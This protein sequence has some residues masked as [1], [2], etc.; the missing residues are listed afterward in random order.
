[1][2]ENASF[3]KIIP[4]VIRSERHRNKTERR[5]TVLHNVIP[6]SSKKFF[7]GTLNKYLMQK[8]QL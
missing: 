6:N 7:A 8:T 2:F 1:M 4:H 3:S 5:I